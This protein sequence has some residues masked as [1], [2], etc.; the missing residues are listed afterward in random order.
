MILPDVLC[1]FVLGLYLQLSRTIITSIA[2]SHA[3]ARHDEQYLLVN[4]L[5][6]IDVNQ[7][8]RCKVRSPF[9]ATADNPRSD[10][11]LSQMNKSYV[12]GVVNKS[13][14]IKALAPAS[15]ITVLR[16]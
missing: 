16:W 4:R 8:L 1:Q 3:S 6:V 15:T 7:Y 9:Q 13:S 11:V 12:S 2:I 14:G 5:T 10:T